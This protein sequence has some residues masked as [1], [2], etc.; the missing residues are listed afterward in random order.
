MR[1]SQLIGLVAAIF[2]AIGV[3]SANAANAETSSSQTE[4]AESDPESS[5]ARS[6]ARLWG[7]S[8]FETAVEISREAWEDNEPR[9]VFVARADDFPDALAGA[10]LS[11][12]PILLVPSGPKGSVPSIV[13][14]EI[15]R[16]APDQVIGLGGKE[17]V[18]THIL[19]KAA[20]AAGAE[21][22]RLA[23]SN[24]FATA[25]EIAQY[26]F[27]SQF[28]DV[29]VDT[30]YV[31]TGAD[32]PD[33]LAAGALEDGPILLVPSDGDLPQATS[34]YLSE[35]TPEKVVAIG[36]TAA[37]SNSMLGQAADAAGGAA[38]QRLSGSN[39]IE[40][41]LA[42]SQHAFDFETMSVVLARADDF[43]DALAAS[44]MGHP[45]L[46][47]HTDTLPK[48]VSDEIDR[49]DPWTVIAVGGQAAVSDDVLEKASEL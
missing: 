26:G 20:D 28:E 15:E 12:G 25:V 38:M 41:A 13:L 21:P 43:P 18:Q 2:V 37:V 44:T 48:S 34:D 27:P 30:A 47:T 32:Y 35:E 39:R 22:T 46:L 16:L 19:K 17:A 49:L 42:V 40:T 1:I 6:T 11:S 4:V 29:D 5:T 8:R 9:D 10:S 24:R 14:E 3:V 45:I 7:F 36:G 31:A 33:A 23:G